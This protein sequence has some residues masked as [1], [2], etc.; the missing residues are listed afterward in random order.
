MTHTHLLPPHSYAAL[1]IVALIIIV[2][3]AMVWG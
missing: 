1:A 2:G 3:I